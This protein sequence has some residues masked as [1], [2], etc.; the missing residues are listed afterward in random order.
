MQNRETDNIE[1]SN[2]FLV[3]G[4]GSSAGGIQA[5]KELFNNMPADCNMA[6]IVI[7]HLSEDHES[8]LHDILGRETTMPVTQ[9][10]HSITIEPNHVYVIPPAKHLEM[11]DNIISVKEPERIRG[12]RV[13]IDRFFR[14]LAT[15]Y[16][17]RAVCIILSGTG[18]D[19]TIGLKQIKENNGF[20]MVQ[21]P[22]EA[23]YDDMPRHAI[24]TDL[25][26]LV[27]SVSEIPQRLVE[28][29]KSTAEFH[30]IDDEDGNSIPEIK[31]ADTLQE[32]LTL[33]RIRTGHDFSSYKTPTL[34]RRIA[35]HLQIHELESMSEYLAFLR[36][37][38]EE[39]PFLLKNL[40]IN[41]TNFFRDKEAFDILEEQVIPQLFANKSS[42]DTIRVWVVGCSSGEE[43]YSLAMLLIEYATR[44]DA[45][46]KIQI[47]AS[48]IDDDALNEAREGCYLDSISLDVSE[49]RLRRFFIKE[50]ER[51]CIRKEV[52]EL[53]LFAPHNVLHDPPF[54]QLDLVSCRN[55]L[56]YLTRDVQEKV[57]Q[58]FHFALL[59]G[60]FLFLGSSEAAEKQR[61]LF[62][63]FDKKNHIYSRI[64]SSSVSRI[65]L[66]LSSSNSW[67]MRL[68]ELPNL[69]NSR[70]HSFGEL[71]H[72]LVEQYAPPSI[73][74]NEEGEIVHYSEHAGTFLHFSGGEP[75]KNLFKLLVPELRAELR[76]A[77]F[78]AR[79]EN[80]T[81]E[82]RDLR[83]HRFHTERFVNLTVHPV[84]APEIAA[85]Y[86]LILLEEHIHPAPE[87]S[88]QRGQEEKALE[89]ES[90]VRRLEEELQRTKDRLYT[91]IEQYEV[92]LEELRASNEEL[93]AINEELRSAT[94]ELETSKEE[95]QSVNEE[96]TT[97]NAELK[98]K[99]EEV[100]R[101]NADLHNLMVSSKIG[102]IFLDRSFQIKRF[103]P[104]AQQLFNII[105]T[106]LGRP[107][108]HITHKLNYEL[109]EKDAREVLQHLRPVEREVQTKEGRWFIARFLPYRTMEDRIDGVVLTFVDVTER[110]HAEEQLWESD[111]RFRA[112][113]HQTT[114]GIGLMDLTG[115]FTYINDRFT[116]ISGYSREELLQMRI[117]DITHPDD[118]PQANA[119]YAQLVATGKSIFDEKRFIRKNGSIVWV[120]NNKTIV[121]HEAAE[122][123]YVIVV[124]IDISDRKKIEEALREA[125]RRKNEFLAT[126]AHELRNPLTP[127]KAALQI[128]ART[129]NKEQDKQAREIIDRQVKKMVHLVDD[130]MDISRITRNKI[131]LQKQQVALAEAIEIAVETVE[132]LLLAVQH[133]FVAQVPEE[134]IFIYADTDRISQIIINLLS[135]AIKYTDPGGDISLTA[136]VEQGQ[137]VIRV[138]DTGIGI[139][140]DR[141][142]TIFEM[143]HQ[144]NPIENRIQSGLGIG[145]SL[146]KKL[147]EMHGGTIQAYSEG[148][149]KGS[150]FVVSLPLAQQ[151]T[152]KELPA[153][154]S[155]EEENARTTP[156]RI[157]IVDDNADAAITIQEA[158][159]L[160]G[161]TVEVSFS[162]QEALMATA[163]FQPTAALIDIGLPDIKG[164]EV[165]RQLRMQFPAMLLIAHSG[166][167]QDVDRQQSQEAGF[168]YHLV[169]PAEI[170][171]I[172]KLLKKGR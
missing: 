125:D 127:I 114:A 21:D 109:L 94:E 143:F 79:E 77:L 83:F 65:P 22:Y 136:S 6:F 44:L 117:Q 42:K 90:I 86:M 60:G 153:T 98:N 119:K 148:I 167:G 126:L 138:K 85:G 57:L 76:S 121:T 64:E 157:L 164:Y 32:I 155:G 38:P 7:A 144:I 12:K 11:V 35:R 115:K 62:F 162:G 107:I 29:R 161:H 110:K 45:P 51:Y 13:S 84:E 30:L 116:Q 19:G 9:V 24:A 142:E 28:L 123:D 71:H 2:T 103:T 145:L 25:V 132:P 23:E 120:S 50:G 146:V 101:T 80:R 172:V 170:E 27:L 130:L 137:A 156:S 133:R 99:I 67:Q 151:P 82:V 74:I 163:I 20:A 105:D 165:A 61:S 160:G 150:E 93:Q 5:L 149:G 69:S 169:K 152:K 88:A 95:L 34:L 8:Y 15:A 141:L 134:P 135:N 129:T 158:L 140:V 26:D 41:V 55:L 139:P 66:M 72:R 48:D 52:R 112:I 40:L 78:T 59:T 14:T 1:Y 91:S 36:K 49:E 111:T 58:V 33:L 106:D 56:I 92:S 108:H 122:T 131:R 128:I 4:I 147:I 46:P 81:V 102:T 53:I 39:I 73:L 166:W 89:S 70:L 124:S 47:F 113:V 16:G 63:P 54:S 100:S 37:N 87:K 18:S 17:R 68:P 96:L 43:A 171:E 10:Q 3:V 104:E 31:G 154:A 168:D 118:L 75:T 97:V 159:Q